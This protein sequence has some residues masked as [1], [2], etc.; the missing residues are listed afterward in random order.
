MTKILYQSRLDLYKPKGGDTI[1]M[2]KTK[3]AIELRDSDI[4]IDIKTDINVADINEYDLVHLFN[5]DWISETYEQLIWAKKHNKKVVLSAIHH[6]E[7]EV[8]KYEKYA[9]YDI[10]RVYNFLISS[11]PLRD[12]FKNLY[13]SFS[14]P[15]KLIP[16]VNQIFRGIRN[17][18][19]Y[20]LE[21]SD[22]VLVQTEIEAGE[23]KKDF[24]IDSLKYKKVVNG[25][26][27]DIFTKA[28]SELF[29]NYV[30]SEH[31]VDLK[32]KKILL[33]VGRVEARKN[34]L[35]IIDAFLDLKRHGGFEDYYL[36]FIGGATNKSHEY[37]SKFMAKV[38]SSSDI[39]YLGLQDQAMVASAM[40]HKGVFVHASWFE[41]TGLVCLEAL[42][43]GMPV[44]STTTRLKEYVDKSI[45]YCVAEDVES[46]KNA[47]I[48][49]SQKGTVDSKTIDFI[50]ENYSWDRVAEQ[51][52]DV[53]RQLVKL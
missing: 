26:D 12:E 40:S 23:I 19:K 3:Q 7:D 18:Q 37:K 28:N 48:E 14:T 34:Q 46:I 15:A 11:Q 32:N 6:S 38:D 20:I 22:A 41:T 9:R 8:K 53:Y 1:Q 13:R 10:R 45:F 21:N 33:C 16:T 24:G 43:A 42:A 39:L 25:V 4:K 49:S 44:V 36:V 51:T 50:R 47:I 29:L 31:K 27:I 52:I 5:V 2:E 30:N 35:A 17:D